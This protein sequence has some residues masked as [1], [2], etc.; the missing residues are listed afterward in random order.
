MNGSSPHTG[1][2][3]RGTSRLRAPDGPWFVAPI[4]SSEAGFF[5][6]VAR[7]TDLGLLQH[8]T[9][10][11]VGIQRSQW[12]SRLPAVGPASFLCSYDAA[13]ELAPTRQQNAV[14]CLFLDAGRAA[15]RDARIASWPSNSNS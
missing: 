6:P 5:A 13:R 2:S 11:S 10:R 14:A 8:P 4:A 9:D 15:M 12:P 1:N 3:V 7:S